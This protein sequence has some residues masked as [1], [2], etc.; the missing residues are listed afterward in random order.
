MISSFNR[1]WMQ[2]E[3]VREGGYLVMKLLKDNC[4]M[5]NVEID[6]E[7]SEYHFDVE[8]GVWCIL[9]AEKEF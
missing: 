9:C 1:K 2:K 4:V 8:D 7:N 3:S 5:C 6:L